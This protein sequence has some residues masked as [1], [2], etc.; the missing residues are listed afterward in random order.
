[1]EL[2]KFAPYIAIS[3]T[4]LVW[5][6]TQRANRKHEVFKERLKKRVDMFDK[7]LPEIGNFVTAVKLYNE[8]MQNVDAEQAANS[9]WKQLG[10]HRIKILCYGTEEEINI[11]EEFISIVER[12]EST[13]YADANN[14][15]VDL[16]RKNFRT[17]LGI[18]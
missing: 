10:D 6:L 8:N 17:E 9:A 3:V 4:L 1:M 11:Y 13:S 2:D 16:V 15:L 5:V 14:K 7:L 12:R 18:K